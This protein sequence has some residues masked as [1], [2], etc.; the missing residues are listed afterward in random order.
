MNKMARPRQPR[1][2]LDMIR[3][4]QEAKVLGQTPHLR[5]CSSPEPW[6][7]HQ[8]SGR[9][10]QSLVFAGHPGNA[11]WEER[12]AGSS[13]GQSLERGGLPRPSD[14]QPISRSVPVPAA[15]KRFSSGDIAFWAWGTQ[16]LTPTQCLAAPD[17]L[18]VHCIFIKGRTALCSLEGHGMLRL[19]E[20]EI[21]TP[22]YKLPIRSFVWGRPD[23]IGRAVKG[24]FG[25]FFA[26]H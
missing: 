17:W 14:N 16:G 13:T 23:A 5:D 12:E 15:Q 26:F 8:W 7:P 25:S 18:G 3:G 19:Q 21:S 24:F 20:I 9:A 6:A 10:R 11:V 2:Q 4:R 22:I 1:A